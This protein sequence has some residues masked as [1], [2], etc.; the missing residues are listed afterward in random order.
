MKFLSLFKDNVTVEVLSRQELVAWHLHNE[1]GKL[2]LPPIQRS[3]VWSNTQIVNYWDSLLRGY[4]SGMIMVHRPK[5]MT[6]N[7]SGA[8]TWE[9]RA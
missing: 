2:L 7:L 6:R 3:L 5:E 1:G 4:P 8:M 9:R